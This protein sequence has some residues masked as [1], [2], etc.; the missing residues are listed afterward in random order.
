M[1]NLHIAIQII[2]A[3]GVFNVWILRF[4]K[5]SIYRAADSINMETEFKAYGFNKM[6][7]KIIGFSKLTL[8]CLLI[9][10]IWYPSLVNISAFLMGCLMVGAIGVHVKINDPLIKSLPAFTM[11]VLCSILMIL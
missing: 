1:E 6:F 11:L 10:G 3:I 7:M 8:A 2:I 9:A 5:P 4:S